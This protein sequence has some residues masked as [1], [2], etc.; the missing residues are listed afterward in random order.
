MFYRKPSNLSDFALTRSGLSRKSEPPLVPLIRIAQDLESAE[1]TAS[2]I[3]RKTQ[4]FDPIVAIASLVSIQRNLQI[5][6]TTAE[7]PS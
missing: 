7:I 3:L 2:F 5:F 6:E 4:S 1:G